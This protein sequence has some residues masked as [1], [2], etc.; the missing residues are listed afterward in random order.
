LSD[1]QQHLAGAFAQFADVLT[2]LLGNLN[3]SLPDIRLASHAEIVFIPDLYDERW[4][5]GDDGEQHDPPY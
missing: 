4:T 1:R 5:N 2:E 3:D